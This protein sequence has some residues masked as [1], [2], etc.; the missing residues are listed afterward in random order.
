MERYLYLYLDGRKVISYLRQR[1]IIAIHCIELCHQHHY[2]IVSSSILFNELILDFRL[3]QTLVLI[4]RDLI[5]HL[6][7]TC[8]W[9]LNRHV[10]LESWVKISVTVCFLSIKQTGVDSTANRYIIKSLAFDKLL[11]E[12]DLYKYTRFQI[13]N[14]FVRTAS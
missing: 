12:M 7:D 4:W 3:T 13:G 9:H 1:L 14:Y 6:E 11:S 5:W 10:T 8:H 2:D